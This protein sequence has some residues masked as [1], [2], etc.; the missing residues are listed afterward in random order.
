M[1]TFRI[2]ARQTTWFVASVDAKNIDMAREMAES[3]DY[4]DFKE[5]SEIDWDVVSIQEEA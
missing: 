1:A 2:L 3:V 5:L 4:D